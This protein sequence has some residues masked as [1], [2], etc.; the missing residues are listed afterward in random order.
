MKEIL[1]KMFEAKKIIA[2]TKIKKAGKNTFSKYEYF[3]PEQIKELVDLACFKLNL[4]TQFTISDGLAFLFV[5]DIETAQSLQF[6]IPFEVPEI[7]ATNKMQQIGGV[8]TYA[9]RYL[10]MTA[11]G[12]VDNNLDFDTTENTKKT[13]E[14]PKQKDEVNKAWLNQKDKAGKYTKEFINSYKAKNDGVNGKLYTVE[15]VRKKYKVSK[16]VATALIDKSL[17]IK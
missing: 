14:A 7:K 9:E 15:D 2:E 5:H 11:F 4:L 6:S 3:E 17:D 1:K 12:I 13:V 8:V 16:A 10:K